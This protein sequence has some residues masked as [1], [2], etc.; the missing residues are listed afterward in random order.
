MIGTAHINEIYRKP[1]GNV[2]VSVRLGNASGYEDLEFILLGMLFDD[3]EL[4]VGET[5]EASLD[6]LDHAAELTAA[7][8]SACASLACSQG[9]LKGLCKKLIMKGFSRDISLEAAQLAASLGLLDE[10]AVAKR[11]AEIMLSRLWGKSRIIHK[12][13]EEGFSED[14]VKEAARLLEDIDFG[15]LCA[16]L[17]AKKYPAVPSER[18]EREKMYAS[19]MRMGYSMSDIREALKISDD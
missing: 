8:V 6:A 13:C 3:M 1:D 11:R 2:R 17:I 15:K 7:Y 10:E 4:C 12:L 16:R 19:L 18:R 9:S 5:D 14:T